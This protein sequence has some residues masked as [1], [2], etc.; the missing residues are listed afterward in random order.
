MTRHITFWGYVLAAAWFLVAGG[1]HPQQPVYFPREDGDLSHYRGMATEI[2]YPDV[3]ADG[4]AEVNG[5]L[6]PFSLENNE[7]HEPWDLTLEEAI[8]ISLAN[9][10]VMRNIGA[11]VLGNSPPEFLLRNPELAPTIYDPAMVESN[12]RTGVEA[13]LSAFDAQF[14]MVA[15]WG[16]PNLAQHG[17]TDS[18]QNLREVGGGTIG[19]F[20]P[21]VRQ[22]DIGT[23]QAQLQKTNI[24]GGTSTIS[25]DWLYTWSNNGSRVTPSD[26]TV[27]LRGEIRQPLLQGAGVQF[28][29]IAGPGAIPGFNNGVMIARINTDVALA[30]FEAAVRNLVYDVESAYWEL[31]FAYRQLDAVIAGRDSGLQSWRQVHEKFRVGSAP[32][33]DEARARQQYF[34]FRDAMQDALTNLYHTEGKL[35]YLMGLAAT[36]GRLIRPADE[37]TVAKVTFDWAETLAEALARNVDLRQQK[38]IVKQ[39]ELELIA[40]KNYLLPRLDLYAMWQFQGLGHTLIDPSGGVGN[41]IGGDGRYLYDPDSNAYQS[42]MSGDFQDW[43]LG[44]QFSMPLGFRKEMSG[45]RYAQLNLARERA[46]LQEAELELSHQL[47]ASIREMES[48][49]QR[50]QTNFNRRVAARD[51]VE[52]AQA[53]YEAQVRDGTLDLVLDAQRRLAEAE[54]A[55]YRS[56]ID[57]NKSIADVHYRKGSL[58]EYNGV[59]LAEGPWPAKAY[60]D[61][62]RRARAR[63][64]SI[65]LDYGFTRPKVVSRGPVEQ[66]A[67]GGGVA[68]A[69]SAEW[70]E[71]GQAS[72]DPRATDQPWPGAA[73]YEM[74]REG[75]SLPAPVAEPL[76]PE[77]DDSQSRSAAPAG[78]RLGGSA[79]P[80]PSAAVRKS[81]KP[82]DVGT[83]DLAA[84]AADGDQ[85]AGNGKNATDR[86][87]VDAKGQRADSGWSVVR[88]AAFTAEADS[89]PRPA[90]TAAKPAEST[91]S[92]AGRGV[93]ATSNGA[94]PE[95][96]RSVQQGRLKWTVPE[97]DRTRSHHRE[98]VAD[99][100]VA[101]DHRP[102]SG[103]KRL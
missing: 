77:P 98:S 36:D 42:L 9:A 26:W 96:S 75:E 52:A 6:R 1:C 86:A 21:R 32:V 81:A 54:S 43:S 18:P 8:R 95:A 61:A 62:R 89:A 14:S 30:D 88:Q 67:L 35:R 19:Q 78:P 103:W 48:N 5:S 33:H 2:E 70:V 50:A 65:Y 84:L 44:M 37:P 28:N 39:R 68:G 56:L 20:F 63:D 16:D 101:A 31:Y 17:K 99:P 46:K 23:F 7:A 79:V 58:L 100:P 51:E 12:P 93:A 66:H 69:A 80:A 74:P 57:Y 73:P 76:P 53:K 59:Y 85:P 29:R 34:A 15:G 45:V 83:L 49:L 41:G 87:E 25:H 82:L 71:A 60:F 27:M 97:P 91:S 13:A 10:K 11:Q 38:W 24:V 90:T 47:A 64:A 40:A 55:Y 3:E 92:E 22:Q 4:L 94:P 102:A 72:E